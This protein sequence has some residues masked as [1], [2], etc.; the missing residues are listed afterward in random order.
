MGDDDIPRIRPSA[1]GER[2]HMK[3]QFDPVQSPLQKGICVI[4]ASAGTGK[5]TAICAIVLRLVVERAIAIENILV[6]TY[7]E[8]A[9]A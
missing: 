3:P 8:L 1:Q 7:T 9:T 6:T 5:T 4:E 2:Q